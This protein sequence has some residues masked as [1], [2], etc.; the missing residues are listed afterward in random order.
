[1]G[2]A[3]ID[4]P[5]EASR[6]P[7]DSDGIT[8]AN[9]IVGTV[10]Y[11]P[12]EQADNS[13]TVDRRSDI[14]SLGCT[15]Y[16]LITARVPFRGDSPIKKLIAHRTD[17]IPSMRAA[18]ADTPERL[19]GVFQ[20]MIAKAPDDRYATMEDVIRE[21]ELCRQELQGGR[22]AGGKA[23]YGALPGVGAESHGETTKT[24]QAS[25]D[26]D[27]AFTTSARRGAKGR[28]EP[29]VG[30]DLGTTFSAVGYLDD[31]GRPQTLANAEG[32]KTTP[33]VILFDGDDVVVGKEAIK[34]MATDMEFVA[35]CAKRDLGLR[36]FHKQFA[37]RSYPPEAL[38][39]WILNKLR[40]DSSQTIGRFE[41]VVVT[42]P[43]YFDEV[44]RKATEDAGYM[45]GFDVM[46][47]IN[48]PTAAAVA[49]GY[50]HGYLHPG[51]SCGEAKKVLVYDLGGGTFD[52]TVMEIGGVAFVALATDGDVRLG[53]R[54]WDQRLVDFV[55]EEFIRKHGLDP[56]ED[57]N[58]LGRLLR[59]CEDAKRTLSARS[60][61]L[62]V[63]DYQGRAER[64][65]VT[66]KQFQ[67]MTLDLL[68][69]TAFT[70]EQTIRAA[71]LKWSD[72]DRVLLVGGS[73]RMPAV[74]EMLARLS[75]KQPDCS[76]SPDEAVA[77][78]AALHAALLLD[79]FAGKAPSFQ[80]KNVNSH[81]LGV[82]AVDPKTKRKQTAVVI[83]R[84]TPLPASA[85]RVFHTSKVGQ[86]SVLVQ[87]VEGESDSP[88]DC[89]QI[90]R[91]AARNLPPNLPAHTPVEVRFRY[92]Q[93][94]RLTVRVGVAG[95]DTDLRHE[96]TR[97]NT[98]TNEQL[99][100]WR[101]SISGLPPAEDEQ[102]DGSKSTDMISTGAGTH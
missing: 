76:V 12:P 18:R 22:V 82:A 99:N 102:S 3:R 11:M 72:I 32:D 21:L 28:A 16:R 61:T 14:Y 25:E 90:G 35:E 95:T 73:T 41:K 24:F 45:A 51:S 94:G 86:R 39:A 36:C 100:K 65:S 84:N 40:N 68:D 38:Q 44:R 20:R 53:G 48:E 2:L 87:I 57:P 75:G 85:K 33:S 26:T 88:N 71:G 97:E 55:A 52:V 98:I 17:P 77:H 101:K 42:V 64:V 50:G 67:E 1:M 78:G 34:A 5:F 80:I 8:Q 30:I 43:A 10:D 59:E 9:Q 92:E 13:A 27:L 70:T 62:I 79:K 15:L 19:D 29:A 58:T 96:I 6:E 23:D 56:R 7:E 60:K 83:P 81:S 66:R 4:S 63:C 93:N 91:C 37:G 74:N 54:D 46:D 31:L 49:Y 69:R 89:V 47:I